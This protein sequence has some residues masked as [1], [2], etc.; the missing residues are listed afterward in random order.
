[1]SDTT[2]A[3]PRRCTA[4]T[5]KGDPCRAWAIEGSDFCYMHDPG[6]AA[7]RAA[8]RSRG[9]KARHGRHLDT[10]GDPDSLELA[11]P[12]DAVAI[13]ATAI[14]DTARLEN[15]VSRNR[16]L[17]YLCGVALKAFEITEL[18]ERMETIERTL[19]KREENQR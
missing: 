1:M 5:R 6:K 8:A 18:A 9:G 7:E 14:R 10:S 11:A 17:G 4:T 3:Y 2:T 16:A 15:S 19:A 13:V 12:G